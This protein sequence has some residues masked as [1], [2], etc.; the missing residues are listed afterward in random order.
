MFKCPSPVAQ[1]WA[2]VQ[3]YQLVKNHLKPKQT[4]TINEETLLPVDKGWLGAV[5][6]LTQ[7]PPGLLPGALQLSQ[8]LAWCWVDAENQGHPRAQPS[9]AMQLP[10]AAAA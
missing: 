3:S 2:Q 10:A 7:E 9:L 1:L 8:P 5:F 6:T 4:K